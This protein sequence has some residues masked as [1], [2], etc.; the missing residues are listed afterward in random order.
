MRSF[1]KK[2]ELLKN[3]LVPL[4]PR[5]RS[6]RPIM[7]YSSHKATD[8]QCSMVGLMQNGDSLGRYTR[9]FCDLGYCF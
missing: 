8:N 4:H 3:K 5:M 6:L 7:I 9:M 2:N 1:L